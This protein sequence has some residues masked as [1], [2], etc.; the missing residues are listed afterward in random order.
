VSFGSVNSKLFITFASRS[1]S[2]SPSES[3]L[4]ISIC[5]RDP[6]ERVSQHVYE[7]N[8]PARRRDDGQRHHHRSASAAREAASAHRSRRRVDRLAK[9]MNKLRDSLS[10]R[11]ARPSRGRGGLSLSSRMKTSRSSGLRIQDLPRISVSTRG[12]G[13]CQGTRFVVPLEPA[14]MPD[15]VVIQ[16]TRTLATWNR[17]GHRLAWNDGRAAGC[18]RLVNA[19]A[20]AGSGQQAYG[21]RTSSESASC[22]LP[23]PAVFDLAHIPMTTRKV[24]EMLQQA[25][26][27]GSSSGIARAMAT[28]AAAEPAHFYDLVVQSRSSPGSDLRRDGAS[29][30]NRAR[31][32]P[33]RA[34][35]P[36]LEPILRARWACRTPGQL[37][38]MRG[39]AGFTG[40]S[41]GLGAD[42]LQAPKRM[43]QLDCSCRGMAPTHHGRDRG[44]HHPVDHAF[45]LYAFP[46]RTGELRAARVRERVL[47]SIT[48]AF[49]TALLNNQP[50]V[51]SPGVARQGRAAPRRPFHPIRRAAVRLACRVE[52]RAIRLRVMYV[53]ACGK[54]GSGNA[55]S[56]G[57]SS[58]CRRC[59]VRSAL[60]DES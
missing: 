41:P 19:S 10:E 21:Q 14:T 46:N 28:L 59:S 2:S 48:R 29:Y 33:S 49:Y 9:V 37:L 22:R 42:G 40:G 11:H 47:K 5:R 12:D 44:V 15:R 54:S 1:T 31:R 30:L 3:A 6:R 27:I 57:R 17:E 23:P 58:W 32:E 45:A 36:C 35:H 60:D 51:L 52:R 20:A 16:W 18:D 4:P 24:Y 38:R 25:E 8:G 50:M 55:A 26:T 53:T 34:R 7:K 13:I 39:A 56:T 43:K